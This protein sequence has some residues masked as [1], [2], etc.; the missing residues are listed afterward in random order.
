M[1][2][3]GWKTYACCAGLVALGVAEYFG[4]HVP[5][6]VLLIVGGGAGAGGRLAIANQARATAAAMAG[7]I[8]SIKTEAAAGT[9]AAAANPVKPA[10]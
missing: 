10:V 9:N 5:E 2:L 1:T 7:L 6:W 4:V 3:N 8:V